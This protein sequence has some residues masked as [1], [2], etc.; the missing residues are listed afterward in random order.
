[1]QRGMS[2]HILY[3]K[4]AELSSITRDKAYGHYFVLLQ[5]KLPLTF[6]LT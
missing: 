5:E 1:M 3:L 4:Q 6:P 2:R